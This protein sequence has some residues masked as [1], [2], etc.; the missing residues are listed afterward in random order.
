M[1][2]IDIRVNVHTDE[3]KDK[4]NKIEGDIKQVKDN[5]EKP[6]NIKIDADVSSATA[7]TNNLRDALANVKATGLEELSQKA[8][9]LGRQLGG[10]AGDIVEIGIKSAASFGP[11]GIAITAVGAAISFASQAIKEYND[12]IAL[13]NARTDE[14]E[15][16]IQNLGNAYPN[17][18][19]AIKS[20]RT[21][22]EAHTAAMRANL[23]VLQLQ[24]NLIGQG[25]NAENARTFTLRLQETANAAQEVRT[26]L[27]GANQ[28]MIQSTIDSGNAAQQQELLGFSFAH[29]NDQAQEQANRFNAL[30]IVNQRAREAIVAHK[31]EI[32]NAAIATVQR[33]VIDRRSAETTQELQ[34]IESELRVA[35]EALTQATENYST[36]QQNSNETA[37]D[38]IEAERQLNTE[39]Q[40]REDLSGTALRRASARLG[41]I[42]REIA[43]RR[44]HTAA[45]HEHE[46]EKQRNAA[47]IIQ[48]NTFLATLEENAINRAAELRRVEDARNMAQ[49]TANRN[50]FT[51]GEQFATQEHERLQR[52]QDYTEA[53]RQLVLA[54]QQSGTPSI[55]SQVIDP[56]LIERISARR[57]EAEATLQLQRAQ[58]NLN[59]VMQEY[60]MATVRTPELEQRR[61]QALNTVT[62]ATNR[63]TQAVSRS[64][65]ESARVAATGL[66]DLKQGLG[67]VASGLVSTGIA[68]AIAGENIG[69]ALKKSLA[70]SL[71]ALAQESA[72][73]ALFETAQGLAMLF[74][75]PPAAGAH[76]AAAGMYA[77]VAVAAGAGAAAATPKVSTP[78]KATT[79]EAAGRTGES[80]SRPDS[81]SE[82]APANITI[83]LN[84]FQ[85]NSAAQDLIVRSL[86]E[87]GYSGRN[88]SGL[89]R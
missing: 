75:A 70:A 38:A 4:V 88:I 82:K 45:N 16:S 5:A 26:F 35:R 36:A 19:N 81:Q 20:A 87:A 77:A 69:D 44:Q 58:E 6:V 86:R 25:M 66:N 40:Q 37:S 8:G 11:V 10:V 9:E 22:Q 46:T 31:E 43:A 61:T 74:T 27:H 85:S 51:Q 15:I 84:A 41:Q 42:A 49:I 33:L 78:S 39:T 52:A 13:D 68:A 54:Q 55:T 79:N 73:K 71:T 21:A 47:R 2:N 23:E 83:N 1:S 24:Q 7:K 57:E 59:S 64:G 80:P 63:Q 76:F 60:N 53:Q 32:R 29:S 28:A 67:G 3:A 50:L 65:A 48:Q 30:V 62:S 72:V 18:T 17:V 89:R 14:L 56:G 34:N 12:A